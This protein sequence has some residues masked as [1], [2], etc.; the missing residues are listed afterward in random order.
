MC[1]HSSVDGK[2]APGLHRVHR[3]ERQ[4][5]SPDERGR[6]C[7][8]ASDLDPGKLRIGTRLRRAQRQRVLRLIWPRARGDCARLHSRFVD[9]WTDGY[10]PSNICSKIFSGKDIFNDVNCVS[11]VRMREAIAR[12][13]RSLSGAMTMIL[14]D[15]ARKWINF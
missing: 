15:S 9:I 5:A 13:D 3:H 12:N 14:P 10:I 11:F 6:H 2:R 4:A 1:D 7:P 8:H